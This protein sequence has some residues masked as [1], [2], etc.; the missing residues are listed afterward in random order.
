MSAEN[1]QEQGIEQNKAINKLIESIT[2]L[3]DTYVE[4]AQLEIKNGLA[5]S[6]T[7]LILISV[8]LFF[9]F[10]FLFFLSLG[11]AVIINEVSGI[12][13]LGYLI[14]AVLNLILLIACFSQRKAIKAKIDL[15]IA[16]RTENN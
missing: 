6:I 5:L 8:L 1:K 14:I 7:Y 3:I 16:A 4:V 13:F 11:L 12:A 10:F 9:S 15:A 2:A